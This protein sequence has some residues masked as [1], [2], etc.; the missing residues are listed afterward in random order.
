VEEEGGRYRDQQYTAAWNL[1][2]RLAAGGLVELTGRADG[3]RERRVSANGS[4][5]L[6]ARAT[7]FSNYSSSDFGREETPGAASWQLGVRTSF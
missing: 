4:Y 7:L 1:S 6:T 3:V 5:A 2:P